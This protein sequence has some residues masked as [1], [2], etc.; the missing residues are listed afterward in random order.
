M[1][2]DRLE[3]LCALQKADLG[4]MQELFARFGAIPGRTTSL[5]PSPWAKDATAAR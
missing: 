3:G 5:F 1:D 2:P 4:C